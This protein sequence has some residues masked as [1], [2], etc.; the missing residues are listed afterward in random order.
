M[1]LKAIVEDVVMTI[2]WVLTKAL[3]FIIFNI[4]GNALY[5]GIKLCS[6]VKWIL[7]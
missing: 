2:I 4:L 3:S 1:V 6:S 7:R 5:Y